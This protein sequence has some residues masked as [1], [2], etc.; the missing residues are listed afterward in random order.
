MTTVTI[1]NI[2]EANKS[3]Y[4]NLFGTL[5]REYSLDDIED[6]LLGLHM[7]LNDTTSSPISTLRSKH[8]SQIS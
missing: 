4:E 8:A 6:L 1:N 3:Q 7:N 2:P 5:A